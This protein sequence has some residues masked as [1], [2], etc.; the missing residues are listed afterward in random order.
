VLYVTA[1]VVRQLAILIAPVMPK[2]ADKLLDQ[3]GQDGE[4]RSFRSLGAGG[5]LRP[6]TWL[7]APAGVFPR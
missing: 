2:S 7:P 3:L 5:R 4:A 6:G 1:E